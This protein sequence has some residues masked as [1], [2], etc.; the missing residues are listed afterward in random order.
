MFAAP[1]YGANLRGARMN[2][3]RARKHKARRGEPGGLQDTL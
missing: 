2:V 3:V 1:H